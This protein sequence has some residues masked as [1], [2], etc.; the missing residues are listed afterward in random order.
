M[1]KTVQLLFKIFFLLLTVST[2]DIYSLKVRLDFYKKNIHVPYF[3][4]ENNIFEAYQNRK[5]TLFIG[6]RVS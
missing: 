6:F 4:L 5:G 3:C 1:L 2:F